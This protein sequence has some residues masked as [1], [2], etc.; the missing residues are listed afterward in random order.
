MCMHVLANELRTYG[1]IFAI[2]SRMVLNV[3][4]TM[5][6]KGTHFGNVGSAVKNVLCE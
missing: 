6:N 4:N 2:A 3:Q 5:K 1:P